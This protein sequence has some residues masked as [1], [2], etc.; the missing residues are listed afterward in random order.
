MNHRSRL[1]LALALCLALM[2]SGSA[3]L[4]G[5]QPAARAATSMAQHWSWEDGQLDGWQLKTSASTMGPIIASHQYFHNAPTIPYNKEGT[6]F[7]STLETA[8]GGYSDTN[9]GVITSP[10]FTLT[11]PIASLLVGGGNGPDTYVAACVYDTSQPY[12]C[13]QVAKAQGANAEALQYRTLDLSANLGAT[14][15]FEMYDNSTGSWGHV[16]L[17]DVRVNAPSQPTRLATVHDQGGTLIS[18]A[19]VTDAGAAGYGVAGYTLYRSTSP[20]SGYTQLNTSLITAASNNSPSGSVTFWDGSGDPNTSYYYEVATVGTDGSVSEPNITYANPYTNLFARGGSTTYAGANLTGIEFPVGPLGTGG[21]LHFGD[22]TRNEGWIVNVGD[23][24][25]DR[26]TGIIPNSFFAVRAQPQGGTAV[27]RAL[28]TTAVGSF[29]AMQSLTF[30]GEYPQASY[31]FADSALPVQV[32]ERVENPMIPGDLK[33]SAIPTAIYD[34]TIKNT[35]TTTTQVSLLATQQNAV[36]YDGSGAIGGTDGNTFSGYGANTNTVATTSTGAQLQMNGSSGAG[37]MTLD[38]RASNTTATAGWTGTSALYNDF[39]THGSVSG[40]TSASSPA[41]QTTVDGA[42]ATSVALA[43][44]QSLTI[45]VVLSWYFPKAPYAFDGTGSNAPNSVLQYTK[46]WTSASDVDQYVTSNLA[47]LQDNTQLY[48]DTLY[49]SQLPQDVLDR[50][51]S[52]IAVLH[53]P[54]AFWTTSSTT[55]DG[56]FAGWEGYGC[57]SNM[58]NHVWEYAQSYARLWPQVGQL[59]DQQYLDE[60]QSNGLIPYRF[61]RTNQFA[62][63]GQAGNVLMA[64]RDYQDTGDQAWLASYWPKI[65]S[66]MNYMVTTFDPNQNGNLIGSALT[67]LDGSEPTASPWLGSMYLAAIN[68]SAHM[69]TLTGDTASASTY[70]SIYSQGR[71]NQEAAFWNGS[72]YVENA[73]NAGSPQHTLGNASDVDMLLGQWWSTQL[74]LGDIYNS[75]HMTEALQALYTNNFKANF[76]GASLYGSYPYTHQWRDFVEPTDAGILDQTWPNN[77][78]PTNHVSY[79]DETQA[80]Y[81]YAAAVEMLQRGLLEQGL[82]EVGALANRYD[83]RLRDDP[84]LH[85]GGCGIGDG[86][87]NPFGEDECGKWYSRSMASWSALTALQG[88]TSDLANHTLG[89]APVYL[90]ANHKSFF[91]AGTTWGTFTQTQGNGTQS[92]QLVPAHGTLTLTTL[93]LATTAGNAAT[94]VTVTLNGNIISGAQVSANGSAATVTFPSTTIAAGATLGVQ[95]TVQQNANTPILGHTYTLTSVNSGSNVDVAGGSTANYA[96]VVQYHSSG[97]SSQRWTLSDAGNGGYYLTNVNS[98]KCLD[99]SAY[100]LQIGVNAIQYSCHGGKNQQWR[101]T[102]DG[103]AWTITNVNS[104]LCLDVAGASKSDGAQIIQWTCR[105]SLNQQWTL[106][107]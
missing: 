107:P 50:I 39:A 82:T 67:T 15:F 77:D 53:T 28:Q 22:G 85:F 46:W 84:Y 98:G 90:P 104:G 65:R 79:Y 44:G 58:P 4:V 56:F 25:H 47:S 63:D 12:N 48:H 86:S 52:S 70:Q 88:F 89:F 10:T 36:G 19:P 27:V 16:T 106:T 2:M 35:G 55:A 38:M 64:Y 42:V 33:N 17:D 34:F 13:R 51:S 62:F 66:A 102:P 26:H 94:G 1:K 24:F 60:E 29:S 81:E 91:T 32:T 101:I 31:Q 76:L 97:A 21:I 45:P 105:G 73:P 5:K 57:C 11:Y 40:V 18:W 9:T 92:D 68:A 54:T 87:G 3:W 14:M 95:L 100:S 49:S 43:A 71:T 69:A 37:N 93:H 103:N 72:Y 59:F 78:M 23:S 41:A 99:V 8:G 80:G 30:Q 61:G 6:Y 83:G 7:L 75:Q 74:G 20:M 96:S